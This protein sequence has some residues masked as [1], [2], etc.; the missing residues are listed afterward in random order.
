MLLLL[1]TLLINRTFRLHQILDKNLFIKNL[2]PRYIMK[3]VLHDPTFSLQFLRTIDKTYYKA[4]DIGECLSTA[5]RIKEGDFES[6]HI[7]WFKTAKRVHKYPENCLARVHKVSAREAYLRAS[8]YYRAAEF[9]LTD[10]E[11]PRVQTT[12]LNSKECFVK[13]P[14]IYL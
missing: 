6:W 8:N 7:E 9:L 13:S 12:W 2:N 1:Q 5:Y 4:A 11:D 14:L 3:V 10:P